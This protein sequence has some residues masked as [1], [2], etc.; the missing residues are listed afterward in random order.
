[1]MPHDLTDEQLD[2][3]AA[4]VTLFDVELSEEL[5]AILLSWAAET[6]I[7]AKTVTSP[8]GTVSPDE[9]DDLAGRLSSARGNEPQRRRVR[10]QR[11]ARRG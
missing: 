5:E 2:E 3:L 11:E 7:A 8:R 1:M 4:L 9:L 6:R 10:G